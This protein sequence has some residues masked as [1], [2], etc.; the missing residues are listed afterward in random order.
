MLATVDERISPTFLTRSPMCS[1]KVLFN[2]LGSNIELLVIHS[3]SPFIEVKPRSSHGEVYL[4]P[5]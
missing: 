3:L 4:D 5:D 2:H 1:L